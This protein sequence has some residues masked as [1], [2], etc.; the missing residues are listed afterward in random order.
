MECDCE[1]CQFV[2]R[3]ME[4][5]IIVITVGKPEPKQPPTKREEF[6]DRLRANAH[7]N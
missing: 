3:T 7:N 2:K 1:Y 4:K 6:L 5:G